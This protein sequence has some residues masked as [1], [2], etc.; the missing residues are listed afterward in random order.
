MTTIAMPYTRGIDQEKL[1]SAHVLYDVVHLKDGNV[2]QKEMEKEI[3]R[4]AEGVTVYEE[5]H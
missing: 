3:D 5:I 2:E 1:D 4:F